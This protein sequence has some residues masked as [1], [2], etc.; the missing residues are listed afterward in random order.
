LEARSNSLH[1]PLF[2]LFVSSECAFQTCPLAYSMMEQAL[3]KSHICASGA[4]TVE[5]ATSGITSAYLTCLQ[6]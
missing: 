2:I 1:F 6:V 3:V 4:S 5:G